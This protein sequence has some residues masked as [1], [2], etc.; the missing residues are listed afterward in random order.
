MMA[1]LTSV[2]W[3]LIVVLICISVIISD[4]QH[5]F[6]CFLAL[7]ISSLETCL[8]RISGPYF[9]CFFDIKMLV[10]FGD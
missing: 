3:Y 10:Y 2:K 5:L 1:V 7:S 4:V 8:F 9:D 6:M